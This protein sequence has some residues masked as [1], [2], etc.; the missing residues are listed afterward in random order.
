MIARITG[1]IE[2]LTE[3]GVLVAVG[4]LTYEVLLTAAEKRR[5]QGRP[6]GE[7]VSLHTLYYIDGGLGG[8]HLTPTLVGFQEEADRDFF[9]LFTTVDGIGCNKALK[10]LALPTAQVSRAIED[11]DPRVLATLKG[12]GARTAQK[13]VAALKGKV[14]RFAL[15]GEPVSPDQEGSEEEADLEEEAVLVLLQLGYTQNE[16]R[17]MVKETLAKKGDINSA[18]ELIE[19]IYRQ[20]AKATR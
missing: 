11:N 17:R 15:P 13:I 8:G 14:A 12:I 7:P 1:T 9:E 6:K 4:G 3:K 16:A 5:F 10:A 18:E 2:G 19:E 20:Q